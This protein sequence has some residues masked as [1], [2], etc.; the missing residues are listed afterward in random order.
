[1]TAS[2]HELNH[3]PGSM[4]AFWTRPNRPLRSAPPGRRLRLEVLESRFALSGATLG[5]D[6]SLADYLSQPPEMGPL[7]PPFDETA[8]ST[9]S[10]REAAALEAADALAADLAATPSAPLIDELQGE[11][12][13]ESP[14]LLAFEIIRIEGVYVRLF[15]TVLDDQPGQL[16]VS[17]GDLFSGHSTLVD[18]TGYFNLFVPDDEAAGAVTAW[19]TDSDENVSNTLLRFLS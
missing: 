1:M 4:F 6:I 12:E 5:A 14:T 3:R 8:G 11:G 18:S 16:I 10:V 7:L 19:V 2:C 9:V 15:G 17:F 13:S